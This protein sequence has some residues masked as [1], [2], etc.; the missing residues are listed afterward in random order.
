MEIN[1]QQKGKLTHRQASSINYIACNGVQEHHFLP[2]L[3]NYAFS[4]ERWEPQVPEM[5][6]ISS[7]VL[8]QA[9]ELVSEMDGH[10]R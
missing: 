10:A 9:P 6:Y 8:L 2:G 7:A 3:W 5:I 4:E 1:Q